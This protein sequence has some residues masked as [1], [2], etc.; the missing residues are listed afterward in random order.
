MTSQ[1]RYY[2]VIPRNAVIGCNTFASWIFSNMLE[3]LQLLQRIA[4]KNCTWNHGLTETDGWTVEHLHAT[5]SDLLWLSFKNF[6]K[7]S[8]NN[9]ILRSADFKGHSSK[10]Y[11]HCCALNYSFVLCLLSVFT[12]ATRSIARYMLR[13]RGWLAGTPNPLFKVTVFLKSII[14]KTVHLRDNV[15]TE[16]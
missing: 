7:C 1:L 10:P 9:I 8:V 6:H 13:Q 15:S 12:R 5:Y 11:S 16:L 2:H 3:S 14:S 4:C